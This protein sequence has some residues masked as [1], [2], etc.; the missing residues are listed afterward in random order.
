MLR[1]L[2]RQR[3]K[4]DPAPIDKTENDIPPCNV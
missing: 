3:Q 4:V 2:H 1:S